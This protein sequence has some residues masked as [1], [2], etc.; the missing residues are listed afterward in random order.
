MISPEMK[1]AIK[2]IK[3]WKMSLRTISVANWRFSLN[4]TSKFTKLPKNVEVDKLKINNIPAFKVSAMNARKDRIVLYLHGGGY[5]GGSFKTHKEFVARLSKI[6]NVQVILIEY[7]LAPENPFPAALEDSIKAY[8][9]II[10]KGYNPQNIFIAGDSAGGGL[11]LATL[12]KLRD[13]KIPLPSAA[14]CI[15]PWTDL[16]LT[17]T[18]IKTKAEMD[19]MLTEELLKLGVKSY[20]GNADP[21]NPYI[22]PLYGDFTGL[23]P[24]L[25]IVG[26]SEI[27]LDDSLRLAE[28]AKKVNVKVKLDVWE[29]MIHTFPLLSIKAPESIQATKNIADFINSNSK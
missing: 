26:T 11:C 29:D 13:E 28:L 16:A 20:V 8:N 27:F 6:A 25:I 12:L 23:P 14:V 22:S 1:N 10:S 2:M 24:L 17:G 5:I 19:P 9:R 21:R 3:L 15:S 4:I 7:R 18:S